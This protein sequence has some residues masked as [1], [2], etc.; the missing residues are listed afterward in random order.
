MLSQLL[1]PGEDPQVLVE[2]IEELQDFFQ[3]YLYPTNGKQDIQ[4]KK[5]PL[6]PVPT[7]NIRIPDLKD[8]V[9]KPLAGKCPREHELV[10]KRIPYAGRCDGC[11]KRLEEK[12]D[13][14][15]CEVCEYDLCISCKLNGIKLPTTPYIPVCPSVFVPSNVN[16]SAFAICVDATG[17]PTSTT[18]KAP[19]KKGGQ[20]GRGRAARSV[21]TG[22]STKAKGR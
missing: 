8:I 1:K 7:E 21:Q 5:R 14:M 16:T 12:T 2:R 9:D 13:V 17:G 6:E 4:P 11:I 18:A 22:R 15:R 19:A 3:T 10:L 20:R